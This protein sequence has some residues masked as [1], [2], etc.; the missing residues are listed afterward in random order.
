MRALTYNLL[1]G[2]ADDEARFPEALA[3]LRAAEPDVLAL[4]EC[5]LLAADGGVRLR[6]LE[7]ALGMKARLAEAA[8]GFHVAL[9][10][11]AGT[12]EQ[13]ERLQAGFA[14]AALVATVRV[15]SR[16]LRVIV[17]HL[18]PFSPSQR[19]REVEA[20]ALHVR[21]AT[22]LLG[23]LNAIS[24][25][26]VAASDPAGWVERYRKR[27]LN[28]H[29]EID[30]R[31]LEHLERSGLVDVHAALHAVTQPTRPTSRYAR[32]ERPIQRLDYIF[33]TPQLARAATA[34]APYQHALAATTSD[35]EPLYADFAL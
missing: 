2:E 26:D 16:E 5:G 11:R 12:F 35:H 20:L 1:A 22:L 24:P 32:S 27:H 28:A 7:A 29:G 34:C 10:L 21:D 18:D 14:H 17:A 31:A 19:L 4:N 8:S 9:A 33:A 3:L 6:Q 30:T 25:R 15:C 23:D 13:L